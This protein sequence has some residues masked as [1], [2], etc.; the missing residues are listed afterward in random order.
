MT[1]ERICLRVSQIVLC[2]FFVGAR[3]AAAGPVP[4]GPLQQLSTA[5]QSLVA[6]VSPSVV[7]VQVTGYGP[8]DNAREGD[9]DLVV[10]KQRSLGSGVIVGDDGYIMTNAHVVNGAQRIDVVLPDPEESAPLRARSQGRTVQAHIIGTEP[11]IDLALLKIDTTAGLHALPMADYDHLRQGELVFA[12]GS[13]DGLRNSVTMG[14]VSAVARQPDRDHPMLYVQTDAPINRGNSGGALVNADGALVGIN[15]F[16]LSESGGSQGIGFA[17]PSSLVEVAYHQ[18]RTFGHLH[19]PQI[20]AKLQTITSDLARGL[21]LR[22]DAGILVSDLLPGGPAEQAGLQVMDI[23]ETVDGRA[24]DTLPLLSFLLYSKTAGDHLT[25]TVRRNGEPVSFDVV[26]QERA[27]DGEGATSRLD[28][29][30]NRIRQL[31]VLGVALDGPADA[32]RL[33]LRF[34]SGIVVAART[35]DPHAADVSLAAGDVIYA[36]NGGRVSTVPEL[37]S[38]LDAMPPHGSVVLQVERE[39]VLVFVA[40][41]LD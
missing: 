32:E 41:E 13:P 26:L 11:G 15:T 21:N 27:H 29:E 3:P 40:F 19:Q 22:Q 31:G 37:Q 23:L 39:G 35:Q 6:R 10:G 5:I 1:A 7:Q 18:L 9:A 30:R 17:I 8:V 16:I 36:V 20:G 38:I 12:F 25:G 33:G 4:L 28:P 34:T 2:V 24:V 14:L